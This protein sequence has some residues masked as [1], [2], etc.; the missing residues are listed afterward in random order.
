MTIHQLADKMDSADKQKMLDLYKT[1]YIAA[2]Q[3]ALFLIWIRYTGQKENI[4]CSKCRSRLMTT[5]SKFLTIVRN[6]ESENAN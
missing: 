5:I 3:E 1:K 4:K 6:A 2:S